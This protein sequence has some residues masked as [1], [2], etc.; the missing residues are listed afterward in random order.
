MRHV[1]VLVALLLLPLVWPLAG[2]AP[3]TVPDRE[4]SYPAEVANITHAPWRPQRGETV[5][6]TATLH[7]DGPRASQAHLLYCRVE[8]QYVCAVP[9]A[10]APSEDRRVWTAEIPWDRFLSEETTHVGYNVTF[11]YADP[12]SESGVRRVGAP[13]GNYWTPA[14]FPQDS[15]GVYYFLA[16]RGDVDG[17]PAPSVIVVVLAAVGL[18]VVAGRRG[19]ARHG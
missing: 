18:L 3:P 14:S 11:R 9:R 17:A 12:Q 8:P 1:A 6:V 13:T 4:S 10:M 19:A 7:A 15:D 2:A 16:Y 5:T